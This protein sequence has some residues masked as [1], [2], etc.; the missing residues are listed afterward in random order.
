MASNPQTAKWLQKIKK[1]TELT[2]LA[3]LRPFIQFAEAVLFFYSGHFGSS[4][5]ILRHLVQFGHSANH[6]FFRNLCYRFL[7]Q[8]AYFENNLAEAESYLGN[9]ERQDIN[10]PI[11]LHQARIV[12]LQA[13][14][15]FR[16]G[17][18]DQ[19]MQVLVRLQR[20]FERHLNHISVVENY[21]LMG[22]LAHAQGSQAGCRKWL[23]SG[24][25]IAAREEIKSFLI[26]S[27]RDVVQASILAIENIEAGCAVYAEA[28]LTG[29]FSQAACDY[30][31][32]LYTN[33]DHTLQERLVQ[34]QK[35]AIL[36]N[37]PVLTV[38]TLGDFMVFRNGNPIDAL[39]WS[40][41]YPQLLLKAIISRGCKNVVLD[42]L[43]EDLWPDHIAQK[44]MQTF[45][46]TLH[47]LR[48]TIEPDMNKIFG[49]SYVF[50]KDGAVSLNDQLVNIDA[51]QYAA[52]FEK[53]QK[54]TSSRQRA[55]ALKLCRN[56]DAMYQGNFLPGELYNQWA[57]FQ[58]DRLRRLRIQQL[59][60]QTELLE[61]EN[62]LMEA[63]DALDKLVVLDPYNE[64][65]YRK[66]ITTYVK[67]GMRAKA[68]AAFNTCR[69]ILKT[70]LDTDPDPE[71][72]SV[73]ERYLNADER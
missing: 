56:M 5:S 14:L 11:G 65:F 72:L 29:P 1:Q 6:P 67:L 59:L 7:S 15:D 50:F 32:G 25:T 58:R 31:E 68:V 44:A 23:D 45:R 62:S 69:A 46:V 10:K 33:N 63:V 54:A 18:Y 4:V 19:A 61:A 35:R 36:K 73:Y 21:L 37:R 27:P 49:S 52:L 47:R 22:M 12:Q 39:Q 60:L 17:R 20:E 51:V 8:I 24:F 53:A 48:K 43:M 34:I 64:F 3:L 2:S 71:T 57:D 55:Y 70:E 28:L 66:L 16:S 42:Q 41:L 38:R 13:I 40:G 26:L 9:C 30:F